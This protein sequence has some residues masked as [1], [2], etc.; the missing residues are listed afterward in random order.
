MAKKIIIILCAVIVLLVSVVVGFII[1]RTPKEPKLYMIDPGD[2]FITN[3]QDSTSLLKTDILLETSNK[4]TSEFLTVNN[5]KIRDVIIKIL[6]N[7]TKADLTQKDT[8]DILER[9]I[10]D[11]LTREYQ[12]EGIENIYFNEFVIQD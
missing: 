9:E 4:D 5:Y 7:K 3:V 2:S 12:V 11:N 1:A 8:Q 10:I 6:R